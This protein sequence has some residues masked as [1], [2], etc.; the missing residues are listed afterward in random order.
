MVEDLVA[1]SQQEATAALVAVA[2]D[3]QHFHMQV[4]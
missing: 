1:L 4:V 2:V 3:G